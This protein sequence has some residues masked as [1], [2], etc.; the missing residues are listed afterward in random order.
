MLDLLLLVTDHLPLRDIISLLH[1]SRATG[2][3]AAHVY[4][5]RVH[6]MLAHYVINPYE[7]RCAMNEH[8]CV[9]SGSAVVWMIQGFPTNWKPND[10]DIYTPRGKSEEMICYLNHLGYKIPNQQTDSPRTKIRR[11]FEYHLHTVT[12]LMNTEFGTTIDVLESKSESA[13][14]PITYLHG[15]L[16]QNY[17]EANSIVSFYPA[18]TFMGMG[19][20]AR[21]S[22]DSNG[23]WVSKYRER[24]F[25]IYRGANASGRYVSYVCPLLL[26]SDGD[27]YCLT[28]WFGEDPFP[29]HDDNH[30]MCNKHRHKNKWK[31]PNGPWSHEP[32]K[33]CR[34]FWGNGP[35]RTRFRETLLRCPPGCTKCY[36]S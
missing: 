15:T 12:T 35:L 17:V 27:C 26:R 19:T 21:R 23:Q 11:L 8:Q 28:I 18:L 25:T 2:Q 30:I 13:V 29:E 7:F 6:Q 14:K 31:H 33:I 24:G 4:I 36:S 1:T 20:L 9:I 22:V 10:L 3:Y 5:R 32:C 16:V 34:P